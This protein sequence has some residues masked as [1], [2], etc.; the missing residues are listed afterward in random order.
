MG[1]GSRGERCRFVLFQCVFQLQL[2]LIPA[3]GRVAFSHQCKAPI[4]SPGKLLEKQ[5]ARVAP[6]KTNACR[7]RHFGGLRALAAAITGG[8]Y[9]LLG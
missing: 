2:R 7:E 6:P 5:H 8:L 4:C 9:L 1:D 3:I